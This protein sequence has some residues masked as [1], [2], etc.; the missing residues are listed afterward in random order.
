MPERRVDILP[1]A[2]LAHSTD[3][4]IHTDLV[5]SKPF[6]ALKDRFLQVCILV[7][8]GFTIYFIL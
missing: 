7:F 4:S 1:T 5:S 2:Q 6:V 8:N 3:A